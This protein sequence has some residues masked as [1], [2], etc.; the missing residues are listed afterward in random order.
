[1]PLP[2]LSSSIPI[3]TGASGNSSFA[4]ALLF[5]SSFSRTAWPPT[6]FVLLLIKPKASVCTSRQLIT[7]TSVRVSATY[8]LADTLL[9]VC[10]SRRS[11]LRVVWSESWILPLVSPLACREAATLKGRVARGDMVAVEVR[12][13]VVAVRREKARKED[14]VGGFVVRLGFVEGV[15]VAGWVEGD[16]MELLVDW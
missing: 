4:L 2:P 8:S 3:V 13:E 6:S 10:T 1:M 15:Y 16:G 9:S 5:V 14:I 11:S 12:R 7:R